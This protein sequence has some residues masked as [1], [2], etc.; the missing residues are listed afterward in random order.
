M[1]DNNSPDSLRGR[2]FKKGKSGNPTGR[3]RGVRNRT[4]ITA[5]TLLEGEAE[6]LTRK[7]VELAL[8][9]DIQALRLCLDRII[10]PRR[11]QTL[12]IELTT[13][14][15]IHY[16]R[17]AMADIIGAVA[18]GE[19]TLSE[20]IELGKLIE[21]YVRTCEASDKA[22]QGELRAEREQEEWQAEQER[23]KRFPF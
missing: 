2:P 11:E 15:S 17:D 4:T 18:A 20:A 5:E 9:G 6:N 16:A 10:P 22:M 1:T 3:P 12:Y 7:A 14:E 23:R 8:N 21:F 13:L 19:I